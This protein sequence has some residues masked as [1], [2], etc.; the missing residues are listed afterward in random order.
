[1]CYPLSENSHEWAIINQPIDEIV[2]QRQ[3][4]FKIISRRHYSLTA[5]IINIQKQNV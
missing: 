5:E 2:F 1:M 4:Y 3:S